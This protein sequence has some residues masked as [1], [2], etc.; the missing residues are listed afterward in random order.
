MA[1]CVEYLMFIKKSQNTKLVPPSYCPKRKGQKS[2]KCKRPEECHTCSSSHVDQ[3]V[4]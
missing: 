3:G 2:S 1:S 4:K